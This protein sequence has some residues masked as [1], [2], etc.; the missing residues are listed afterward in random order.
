[1]HNGANM[2]NLGSNSKKR[3]ITEKQMEE[4]YEQTEAP[5]SDDAC[6]ETHQEIDEELLKAEME[7]YHGIMR[8]YEQYLNGEVTPAE[9]V[10]AK[11]RAG[12]GWDEE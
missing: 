5:A 8:G 12:H 10:F 6:C 9:E 1:M 3:G 11:I 4:A 7:T 2:A